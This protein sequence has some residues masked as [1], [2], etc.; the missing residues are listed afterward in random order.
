MSKFEKAALI[1]K[2]EA[3]H[4]SPARVAA[5]FAN[6]AAKYPVSPVQFA[7]QIAKSNMVIRNVR[8]SQLKG[9]FLGAPQHESIDK[10]YPLAEGSA[11]YVDDCFDPEKEK[12]CEKKKPLMREAKLRYVVLKKYPAY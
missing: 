9:A 3:D 1:S 5:Y 6:A 12:A 7:E 11:I 4:D 10:Y 2:E 8:V